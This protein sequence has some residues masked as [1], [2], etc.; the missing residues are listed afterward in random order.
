MELSV[1]NER[2]CLRTGVDELEARLWLPCEPVGVVV[3]AGENGRQRLRPTGDYLPSVLSEAR[4][5]TLALD[6]GA[7]GESAPLDEGSEGLQQR[8]RL[9]CGWVRRHKLVGELP[10][11]LVG[12]GRGAVAALESGAELGRDLCALAA[13]GMHCQ[14]ALAGMARISAPT[15]LIAGGLDDAAVVHSRLAYAALRCRKRFEIVPG[16]TRAF[17]EPGSLEVVARLVR[18]WFVQ[19]VH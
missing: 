18:S 2:L 8:L 5:A 4:L 13:R 12:I 11:G 14:P 3:L 6:V 10:L 15:L 19:H 17:D 9:A 7:P 16:A 1:A